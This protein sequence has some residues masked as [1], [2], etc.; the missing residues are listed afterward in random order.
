MKLFA[1]NEQRIYE[2]A[3]SEIK[4]NWQIFRGGFVINE[5]DMFPW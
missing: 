3:L 2:H 4:M 1:P 5:H